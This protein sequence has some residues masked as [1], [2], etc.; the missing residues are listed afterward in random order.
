MHTNV[1]GYECS[2][3]FERC[4]EPAANASVE[5]SLA[6]RR[7]RARILCGDSTSEDFRDTVART[8]LARGRC[9]RLICE[10]C[11]AVINALP[12]RFVDQAVNVAWLRSHAVWETVCYFL[13]KDVI[14]LEFG[15]RI[16][17]VSAVSH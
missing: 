9:E 17:Y 15:K 13:T 8:G 11:L 16:T 5:L 7:R 2:Y 4:D 10:S 1:V 6:E 14:R 12:D 3:C